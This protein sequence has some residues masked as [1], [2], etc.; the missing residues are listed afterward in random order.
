MG[1][2]WCYRK[3]NSVIRIV[4]ADD[5]PIFRYALQELLSLEDDFEIIGEAIDGNEALQ[6]VRDLDPDVLL[7]DMHMPNLDGLGALRILRQSNNRTKVIVLTD[8][9]AKNELAQAM[10]LGCSGIVPKQSAPAFIIKSIRKVHSGEPWSD[11]P[12]RG[13]KLSRRETEIVQLV[14]QGLR[15]KEIADKLFVTE[16]TVKNHVH[17]I[18]CKLRVSGRQQ[19]TLYA[20]ALPMKGI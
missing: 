14:A 16:Q 18:F 13:P 9:E 7:L 10:K 5:H 2:C 6:R 20:M 11:S 12:A 15:N 3:V 8:A 19:L 17:K 1:A 4:I